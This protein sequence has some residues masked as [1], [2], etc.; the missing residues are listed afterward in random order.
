MSAWL[1]TGRD[2]TEFWVQT[3]RTL[4]LVLKAF[5]DLRKE[6][7][8]QRLSLAW[9]IAKLSRAQR[10]PSLKQLLAEPSTTTIQS[11]DQMRAAFAAWRAAA[12]EVNGEG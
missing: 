4:A 9:H 8:Q 3:P 11:V 2:I 12:E 5:A 1:R 10:I 7:R 6:E